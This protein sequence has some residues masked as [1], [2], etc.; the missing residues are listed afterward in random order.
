MSS[1]PDQEFPPHYDNFVRTSFIRQGV[2]CVVVGL[3][4]IAM[5]GFALASPDKDSG[6]LAIL[7]FS[8]GGLMTLAGAIVTAL[9][10]NDRQRIK[11]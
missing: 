2:A 6:L 10:H 5:G 11:P 1:N 3:F 7:L 8:V 9:V 4:F